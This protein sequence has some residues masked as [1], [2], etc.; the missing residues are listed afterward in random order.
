MV[1]TTIL[2][3]LAVAGLASAAPA[4]S[5]TTATCTTVTH[6]AHYDSLPTGPI[7]SYDGLI[8][9]GW[10]VVDT[11]DT[12]FVDTSSKHLLK[13]A[14]TSGNMKSHAG[15][16]FNDKIGFFQFGC[17][18][19]TGAQECEFN[20]F[21]DVPCNYYGCT[22]PGPMFSLLF[23]AANYPHSLETGEGDEPT[24]APNVTWTLYNEG[25][26]IDFSLYLANYTYYTTDCPQE[27]G[28]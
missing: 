18:N 3:L 14:G 7:R 27:A 15:H 24:N 19:S 10:E 2:G 23:N 8:Y 13:M 28:Y 21:Y 11:Q 1:I 22:P 17:A 25:N 16:L 6:T 5:T 26:P 20:K 12:P 9:D 4:G